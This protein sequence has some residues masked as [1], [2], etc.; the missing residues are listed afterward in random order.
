MKGKV[1]MF[2]TARGFG[3]VTGDDG[4]DVYVHTSAIEGGATLAPG[5]AV[6]YEVEASER[7]SRAKSLKKL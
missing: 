3:F 1:K 6:E 2:N 7:G 5:D 4:K